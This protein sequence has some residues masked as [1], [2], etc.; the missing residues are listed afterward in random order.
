MKTQHVVLATAAIILLAAC[1]TDLADGLVTTQESQPSVVDVRLIPRTS[2]ASAAAALGFDDSFTTV[3]R[4]V[5]STPGSRLRV[6]DASCPPVLI[7]DETSAPLPARPRAIP[8]HIEREAQ[9]LVDR[10]RDATN[11]VSPHRRGVCLAEAIT[12][13]AALDPVADADDIHLVIL[14]PLAEDS[15]F[16]R[17]GRGRLPTDRVLVRRAS[18]QRLLP[19]GLLAGMRVHLAAHDVIPG[20]SF[21]RSQA[22][23]DVW[24]RLLERAGAPD[25]MVTSGAPVLDEGVAPDAEEE[26]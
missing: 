26:P 18:A 17:L 5:A 13:A 1:A 4:T 8:R 14:G 22:V 10:L 21:G 6:L 20:V 19:R 23:T 7:L 16:A 24:L 2:V 9:R 15:R 25:V 12:L 3:A 11:D